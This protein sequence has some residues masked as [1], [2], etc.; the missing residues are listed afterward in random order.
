MRSLRTT[1]R[2]PRREVTQQHDLPAIV[3]QPDLAS[4]EIGELRASAR[5]QF[6]SGLPFTRPIGFDEAFDYSR[7]LWDVHTNVGTSRLVLD[8]PLTGRLPLVHRLDVSL[9]REFS[10]ST[11]DLVVQ[12]G[13][14]NGYD[15]RNMFYYDLF[16]GRRLDQLPR[17]L[18]ASVAFRGH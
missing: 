8:K 7:K 13:V 5:W 12:A 10:L 18:Y 2:S 6:G 3:R 16:T 14:I 4:L 11:G 1:G 17:A 15:R 9:E